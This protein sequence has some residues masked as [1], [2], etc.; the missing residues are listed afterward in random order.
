MVDPTGAGNA[1]MGGLGVAL[2]EGQDVDD[3]QLFCREL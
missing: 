1:F 2:V 3:G